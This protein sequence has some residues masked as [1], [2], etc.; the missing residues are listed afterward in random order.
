MSSISLTR[1]ADRK[2]VKLRPRFL[3]WVAR[4]RSRAA[5]SRLDDHLLADIGVDRE[6]ADREASRPFWQQ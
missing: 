4:H 5:L 1:P 3:A 2:R 6:Y